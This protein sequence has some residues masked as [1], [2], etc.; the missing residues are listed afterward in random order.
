MTGIKVH[1][2][3]K[4]PYRVTFRVHALRQ[5]FMRKIKDTDISELLQNGTIIEEYGDDTPYPSY[6]VAGTG[7]NRPLHAV[8]AYDKEDGVIIVITSYEPDRDRWDEKFTRRKS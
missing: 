5:M 8:I 1:D 4:E 2:L 7:S 3:V 6:L